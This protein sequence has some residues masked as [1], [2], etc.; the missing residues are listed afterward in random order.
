MRY[1]L[2][3]GRFATGARV[4][5]AQAPAQQGGAYSYATYDY[6]QMDKNGRGLGAAPVWLYRKGG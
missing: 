6:D 5:I 4:E 2:S 3:G 1:T